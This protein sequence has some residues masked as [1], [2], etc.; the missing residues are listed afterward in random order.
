MLT[1]YGTLKPDVERAG[2]YG[3]AFEQWQLPRR[4]R[5]QREWDEFFAHWKEIPRPHDPLWRGHVLSVQCVVDSRN[6][7]T[8][9][10]HNAA[11]WI[12]AATSI[13]FWVST[14]VFALGGIF[15]TIYRAHQNLP[16]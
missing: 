10:V 9:D 3:E 2:W 6:L 5:E 13:F 14:A 1:E 7:N 11:H 4:L 16:Y 12:W 8:F 15:L